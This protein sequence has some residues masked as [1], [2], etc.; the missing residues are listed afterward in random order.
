MVNN[1]TAVGFQLSGGRVTTF[2]TP[3]SFAEFALNTMN[4]HRRRRESHIW[5]I[6]NISLNCLCNVWSFA[7]R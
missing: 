4:V 1:R 2:F 3:S 7:N 5:T 6:D